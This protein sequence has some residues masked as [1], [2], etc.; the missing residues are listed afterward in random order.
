MTQNT[1]NTENTAETVTE[2][3]GKKP[4]KGLFYY[5]KLGIVISSILALVAASAAFYVF[6]KLTTDGNLEKLINKELTKATGMNVSFEKIGFSFP[7]ISLHNTKIAT[8]TPEMTLISH[9]ETIFVRPDF[10]AAIQGRFFI[11]KIEVASST[12]NL[13]IKTA[14]KSLKPPKPKITT[15]SPKPKSLISHRSKFPLKASISQT[16]TFYT[17]TCQALQSM[18]SDST[19]LTYLLPCSQNRSRFI[20]TQK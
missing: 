6:H 18:K 5:I 2:N 4:R 16:L 7:T 17:K 1:E 13:T 14:A 20:L 3:T 19:T 15:F 9:T 11:D 10:F 8:D 12:N